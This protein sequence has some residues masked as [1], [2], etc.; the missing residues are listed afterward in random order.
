MDWLAD[1][2]YVLVKSAHLFFVISWMVGHLYLPRLMVYHADSEPGSDK[3]ETFKVMERR[4]MRGI[5][6]PAMIGAWVFGLWLVWLT[7]AWEQGWFA[8]KF[9]LVIL[10]SAQHGFAVRWM[11]E[12]ERDERKRTARFFRFVN[13]FPALLLVAIIILVIVKPF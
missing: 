2:Q 8:A 9:F 13:E 12:F 5:M 4:L 10:M 11:K 6:T 1:N 3:S 7:A